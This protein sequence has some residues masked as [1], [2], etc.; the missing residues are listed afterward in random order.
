MCFQ[1]INDLH[2]TLMFSGVQG[3]CHLSQI[4]QDS[5]RFSTHGCTESVVEISFG[6][7]YQI[8]DDLNP[9]Q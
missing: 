8:L 6:F 4:E 9:A 1:E 3:E 2:F 7:E 5:L